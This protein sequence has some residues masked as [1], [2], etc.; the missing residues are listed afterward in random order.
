MPL[1]SNG[2]VNRRL[3]PPPLENMLTG[4]DYIEARTSTEKALLPIWKDVLGVDKISIKD[5]FF[6]IG[7]NSLRAT[8]LAYKIHQNLS[9]RISVRNVFEW[10]TMRQMAQSIDQME[11]R[12]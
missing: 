3:L 1:T 4:S 10:Q 5:S 8:K 11:Q 6:D 12:G 2:K 7:G 9:I